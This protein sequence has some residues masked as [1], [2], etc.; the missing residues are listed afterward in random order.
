MLSNL[1]CPNHHKSGSKIN[2][3]YGDVNE[4]SVHTWY[5]LDEGA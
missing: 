1:E 3:K 5:V 2:Y 4:L